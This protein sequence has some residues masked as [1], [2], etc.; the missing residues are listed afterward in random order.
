MAIAYTP[1]VWDI[2]H[3]GHTNVIRQAKLHGDRLIV[4][5]CSDRLAT[6]HGKRPVMSENDRAELIS[7][8]KGVDIVHVYD[9]P[10]QTEALKLYNV[11]VFVV[12]EEF[13]Q[14]GV[15]EHAYALDYCKTNNIPI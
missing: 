10:D 9:N 15:P 14:Q 11:N 5:V 2:L 1:G 8:L 13:G 6:V 7:N 12:G 4:G 3:T